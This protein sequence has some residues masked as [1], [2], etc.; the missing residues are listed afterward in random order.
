VDKEEVRLM[1]GTRVWVVGIEVKKEEMSST[2]DIDDDI[3]DG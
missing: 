1:C 3:E 2:R